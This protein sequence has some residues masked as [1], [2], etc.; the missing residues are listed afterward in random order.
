M[1][2]WLPDDPRYV[3]ARFIAFVSFIVRRISP[4]GSCFARSILD[5]AAVLIK[6]CQLNAT[7]N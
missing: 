3:L 1:V 2:V 4:N 5:F 7:Y 6:G